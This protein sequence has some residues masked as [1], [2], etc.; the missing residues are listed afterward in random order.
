MPQ[1][2]FKNFET[3]E[4]VS[5]MDVLGTPVGKRKFVKEIIRDIPKTLQIQR[6][7]LFAT[8]RKTTLFDDNFRW[9]EYCTEH[10]LGWPLHILHDQ[11]RTDSKNFEV[12]RGTD[13][14][15][16]STPETI[17]RMGSTL[18]DRISSNSICDQCDVEVPATEDHQLFIRGNAN[19]PHRTQTSFS[20]ASTRLRPSAPASPTKRRERECGPENGGLE[21][22]QLCREQH[23]GTPS[24]LETKFTNPN[25]FDFNEQ[26]ERQATLQKL[27]CDLEAQYSRNVPALLN[28]LKNFYPFKETSGEVLEDY[29]IN[30]FIKLYDISNVR[31]ILASDDNYV[32]WLEGTA[33]ICGLV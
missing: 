21:L 10:N 20:E 6:T 7:N 25:S 33:G 24:T 30:D 13:K 2:H 18:G 14:F 32:F 27:S 29:E 26:S 17:S 9:N 3:K 16:F 1:I 12:S 11:H 31:P 15:S 5:F 22:R 8:E 4:E 28:I 19:W 23:V